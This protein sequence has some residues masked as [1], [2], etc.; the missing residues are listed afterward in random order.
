MT[1]TPDRRPVRRTLHRFA[2]LLAAAGFLLVGSEA[3]GL[4]PCPNHDGAVATAD[5]EAADHTAH[6]PD[7]SPDSDAGHGPCSCV[8]AG[9][10]GSLAVAPSAAQPQSHET[11][12]ESQMAPLAPAPAPARAPEAWLLPFPNGPPS[13]L[14]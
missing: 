5:A 1:A 11:L 8:G 10:P 9:C 7:S 13:P 2:A 3:F 12:A 6:A 14:S 4:R